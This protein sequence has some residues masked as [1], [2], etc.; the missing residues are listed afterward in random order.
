[1][2]D[3][4]RTNAD[5]PV[6]RFV[7]HAGGHRKRSLRKRF[8]TSAEVKTEPDGFV[9]TLDGRSVKTPGRAEL[10]LP[11]LPLATAVADEWLAQ[12]E[13][14]DP[15]TMPLTKMANTAI[16]R[17]EGIRVHVV[18]EISAFGASDLLCYRAEHPAE[19]VSRQA[20][21]W[22]PLLDWAAARFDAKLRVVNG[23]I[24]QQQPEEA[25][26][27]L[28]ARVAECSAFQLAGLHEVVSL[29]GSL[30]LGLAVLE[31]HL[32]ADQA[33]EVAHVDEIWQ[34]EKWGS[35]E[36]AEARLQGRLKSLQGAAVFLKSL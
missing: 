1:M 22:D 25:L 20:A 34:V 26:G 6:D 2:S 30:V 7:S 15:E 23:I 5:K 27:A 32:D 24:F 36:E 10:T 3:E 11:T 9:L 33:F 4:N 35:D 12:G 17:L 29:A 18:D 13:E 28:K 31:H 14:I 21:T 19:L 16:D 8:Y